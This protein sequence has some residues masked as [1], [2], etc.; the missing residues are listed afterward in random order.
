MAR[1]EFGQEEVIITPPIGTDL[2]GYPE[3]SHGSIGIHDHLQAKAWVF[4]DGNETIAFA[5]LDLCGIDQE[6]TNRVRERVA[7]VTDLA[8]ENIFLSFTHTHSGHACLPNAGNILDRMYSQGD[9]LI[10]RITIRHTAGAIISAYR[11]LRPGSIGFGRGYLEGLCTNRRHPE[12]VIDHD[13]GLL[14][15]EESDGRLAGVIVNYGCHPT[16][17]HQDNYLISRDFPGFMCDAVAHSLGGRV[18]VAFAQGT[19][20]DVSTRWA[21]RGTTF[22]EAK[23]LGLMLAGESLRVLQGIETTNEPGISAHIGD[24]TLPARELPPQEE[25]ERILTEETE[26]LQALREAEAP[27]GQIRTQYVTQ[28][29]AKVRLDLIRQG[30]ASELSSEVGVIS[31]GDCRIALL[32]GEPFSSIGLAIKEGLGEKSMVWG[33]INQSLGYLVPPE[34]EVKGGYEAG[35]SKVA[36]E[37]AEAVES[38]VLSL[39]G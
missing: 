25:A 29:G 17:L 14:R 13:V 15:I 18:Q 22:S 3:R 39:A 20:G 21:R 33:Y 6:F 26:R 30:P 35:A 1:F 12:G 31:L 37:G 8:P 32:P 34:A 19:A 28:L 27:Y 5:I 4:S 11:S 10:D 2:V 23:R 16:V 36:P 38:C 9:P 24:V 7:E